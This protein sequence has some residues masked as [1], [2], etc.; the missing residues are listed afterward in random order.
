MSRRSPAGRLVMARHGQTDYNREG[1]LQG[2][3]DIALNETGRAQ[4]A[5][6]ARAMVADP[7][8]VIVASPLARALDTARAVGEACDVEVTTSEA[9]LE[10]GFGRWEGMTGAEMREGWPEEYADLRAHRPVHGLGVEDRPAVAAR[11]AACCRELLDEHPGQTVMVV[12]H[13]ASTTLGITA[14][15]GLPAD[16]FLGLGGL[17][18]CHRSLLEPLA[19]D[20]EGRL[21]RLVSH[22]LAPDFAGT[23]EGM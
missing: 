3:I 5:A 19:A 7:P 9:L 23:P 21:M 13:G 4:A 2:Q 8:D 1:R 17:E 22:N 6:L 15:L 16:G 18:N 11:V 12:G 14:L 10:R 20:P